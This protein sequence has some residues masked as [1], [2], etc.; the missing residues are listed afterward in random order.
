MPQLLT[1]TL[2]GGIDP[3]ISGTGARASYAM[4]SYNTSNSNG[5]YVLYD[6]N[7]C[8][9]V[10]YGNLDSY[11]NYGASDGMYVSSGGSMMN[12]NAMFGPTSTSSSASNPSTGSAY[13]LSSTFTAGEF[14]N[15]LIDIFSDGTWKPGVRVSNNGANKFY[16]N[17]TAIN[18]DHADKRNVY[19]LGSGVLRCVDRLF[20]AY[21]YDKTG[22]QSYSISSLDSN[23][24]G[25]ASY[26]YGRKELVVLSYVSSSGSYNC[27]TFSNVDFNLYPSPNVALNRPEVV[28]TNNTVSFP[29]WQVNNNESY[30]NLKPVITDDGTVFVSVMFPSINFSLYR[31]TRSGTS[32]VT[33]TLVTTQSISTS[34]GRESGYPHYGQRQ[35][36]SRDGSTVCMFCPYYYYGS[37]CMSY[38]IDK[39]NN[40]YGTYSYSDSTYGHIPVPYLDSGWQFIYAGNCYA[41]NYGGAYVATTRE[42]SPSGGFA[43][44]G[45]T[46]Y[47]T[48]FTFPNT[49]N[50]PGYTQVTDYALLTSNTYGPKLSR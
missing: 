35:I 2:N 27:Y 20:G 36:T 11:N 14:G 30:Y 19:L 15:A 3:G 10:N 43:T 1:T 18:S 22:T 13:Y 34:Y 49:T 6:G 50:Y 44:T 9:P 45:S 37:G 46:M 16:L 29:S 8:P 17:I 21:N 41:G 12:Y 23:M 42:K 33:A 7:W 40:T 38:M 26:H 48:K 25:S 24:S 5:G 32:G 39:D 28:R 47:F 4:I 31:F